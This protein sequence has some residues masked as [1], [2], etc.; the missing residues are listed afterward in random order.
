MIRRFALSEQFLESY[1]T[2]AVPWGPIGYATY[3]RTYPRRLNETDPNAVGTEEWWQTCRRVIEGMFFIQ[4]RHVLSLGLEWNNAKAQ[5]TA[6]DAYDRL[7]HLKWTPPG[8]GLWM[9]GT[10]FVEE[11]TAAGL[12]NCAFKSTKDLP[13]KGGNIFAWIMDALMLGVGVGF[14]TKGERTLT[15]KKPNPTNGFDPLTLKPNTHN[16]YIFP[17]PNGN[18]KYICII[19]DS[20]EGWVE[21]VEVLLN[22]FYRGYWLPEFQY[23]KIRGPNLPIK[24]FGGTSSGPGPLIQLHI[25]LIILYTNVIGQLIASTTL[26]E[27]ENLIGKCVVA[28]NVR[29]SAALALGR[30]DDKPYLTLKDDLA[31]LESHTWGSNNSFFAEVG[32]D[33]IWHA[34]QSSK[35]GEPGYFW[36]ANAQNYGRMGDP[37]KDDDK[38]VEGLNPCAE[39]Q[40]EDAELCNVPETF[41]S[42][43]DT[44]EDYKQTAKIAYL[45]GKT[46]TLTKTHWP[47]TNAKM[48]KNRRI[49]CGMSGITQAISKLGYREFIRWCDLTYKYIQELDA[50]YSDWLCIPRSKRTTTI[51]PSGTVSKLP[52]VPPGIHWPEA[53]YYINRIRFAEHNELLPILK[54]AGYH[55]EPCIYSPKTEVVSFPVHEPYF[56]KGKADVTMWEQLEL[57]AQLQHYWSD[58]SVSVTVTFQDGEKDQIASALEMYESRLKAVSFLR[59]KET[60][61]KQAPLEPIDKQEYETMIANITPIEGYHSETAGIGTKYCSSTACEIDWSTLLDAKSTSEIDKE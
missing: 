38:A 32:M 27:T 18:E 13:T 45:Y 34:K 60:G 54:Q 56:V 61:Y 2:K 52:G 41:P 14:D 58:N 55:V 5:R 40:L 24:G 37:P 6:K 23:H 1:K 39:M 8:R 21:S 44:L 33:Y 42:R 47:D 35:K 19:A 4:K 25:D 12:F 30:K 57:A 49:G 53:E 59:Y 48:Q 17:D 50:K 11:R 46:V 28:G 51:K 15:V 36:L 16:E 43:H 29:R 20:R 10:K 22:C 26:V 31:K 9:M 7:F 3:K